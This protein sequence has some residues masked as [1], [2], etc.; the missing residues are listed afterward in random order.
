MAAEDASPAPLVRVEE[1]HLVAEGGAARMVVSRL[2]GPDAVADA[3]AAAGGGARVVGG[4]LRVVSTPSRLADAAGRAGGAGLARQVQAAV[5][6]AVESWEGP[7]PDLDTPA[8]PLPCSA[9]PVIM[10]VVN[11]TPDSFSDGGAHYQP[12]TH[13]EPAVDHGHRLAA[14]GADILDVGG[15]STRP[16]ADAV[17]EE[18]ELR[19]VL[20][21]VEA[22]AGEGHKVSVDTSK[23]GV[24]RRCVE[25]GACLVNDVSAGS[26]DPDMLPTVAEL[27]SAYLAMHMRG[28]PRTMQRDPRYADV[29]AEVFDFLAEAVERLEAAGVPRSRVAVDPGIGFGKTVDH[30]LALLRRLREFTSLGRPVLVGASRKS[31]I[32]AVCGVED[33][34]QRLVGSLVAAAHAVACRAAILRVHDVGE[35][36]QA[37]RMAHALATGEWG[38]AGVPP[39]G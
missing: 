18:E 13:P 16:G 23:A 37:A 5:T 39:T 11:V 31:F 26:L 10:G 32:G 27:G 8:G 24:A 3:V 4:R 36:V 29:V 1:A 6:A 25:A 7:V 2:E 21:V 19:R 12:E 20:P 38:G 30:N 15:E 35:T 28:T 34:G 22:L 14:E 9:R 33:T 17:P